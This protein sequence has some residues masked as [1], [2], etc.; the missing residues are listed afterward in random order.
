MSTDFRATDPFADL[1]FRWPWRPYQQRVLAAFEPHLAD[2]RL[3]VVAAPG[4][5]KTILGLEAFRRLRRPAVVLSPTRTVREQWLQRLEAFLAPGTA[6]PRWA[7]RDLRAP[8]LLTSITY[9]ALHSSFRLEDEADED[10]ASEDDEAP[11]GSELR[12]AVRQLEAA[13]VGL[14]ILDEAHHLRREWWKVLRELVAALERPVLVSLTATPPYDV[15]G[16]E[17]ARYEE[18]CGPIDEEI[19]VPELVKSGTLAPHQDYVRI[20]VPDEGDV[21]SARGYDRSVARITTELLGDDELARAVAGHPWLSV[22]PE[23]AEEVFDDPGLAVALLVFLRQRGEELPSG[24]LGALDCAPDDLPA[25]DRRWWQVL[26]HRYLFDDRWASSEERATHR[27]ALA[28]RLRA[29]GLLW[30][31]ELRLQESRPVRT[32]LSMSSAK[33]AACADIYR[34]ERELRGD[35]LRQVFLADFIRDG[36]DERDSLGACSI[37]DEL[38]RVAGAERSTRVALLTGRL[39]LLHER[40]V[41]RLLGIGGVAPRV[42]VVPHPRYTGHR[43]LGTPG[44]GGSLVAGMTRLL[45]EGEI[46]VLVGTRALLGEGWDAPAVNSLV[47][48]SYVGSFVLS[49][50]MRGRAIRRDPRDGSKASSIWHIAAV[51]P[52]SET[53]FA[54]LEDLRERLKTFVGLA[55]KRPT[56]ESGIDR[57]D[58]PSVGNAAEIARANLHGEVASRRYERLG[59]RWAEA[60]AL[61]TAGAVVPGVRTAR[62]PRAPRALFFNTLKYLAAC[63]AQAFVG[64]WAEFVGRVR[65]A[66][67][68][69]IWT[70]LWVGALVAFLLTLPGL[71][72]TALLWWRCLPVDGSL[73]QIGLALKEALSET[74]LLE[75]AAERLGVSTVEL[76]AGAWIVQLTGGS[77]RDQS[78]FADALGEL[79][80]PIENPR[81][82]LTRDVSRRL[83]AR[84]DYHAVPAP[85]GAKKERAQ[86]MHR[87]W[88]RRLGRARLIYTR[89]PEGRTRLLQARAR[90]FSTGFVDPT[91]RLDRW[92]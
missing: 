34:H 80:G 84:R 60:I 56:I 78:V 65:S 47:L 89:T 82:M 48:A 75:T 30:R 3:H 44:G 77:F 4:S 24:L 53:G 29:E 37:F 64:I 10:V 86:A 36:E 79:L 6:I 73:K 85:L 15:V 76:H 70:V 69:T 92:S 22:T 39:V 71:I 46:H 63:L 21:A 26:V 45:E 18:L 33:I 87:H 74:G 12:E 41:E 43:K 91:E 19:S 50:Q 7:S 16:S 11:S 90:A 59:Q 68:K 28:R 17:W 35:R 54:D 49:N 38:I 25:L 67:A 14:V 81:Y 57:L 88:Q 62:P 31:R 27:D 51:D 20:V 5:G 9:Q 66:D 40:V 61:G 2:G 83:G 42:E 52:E 1:R 8:G 23:S 72:R 32:A 55:E 58:I 13:G